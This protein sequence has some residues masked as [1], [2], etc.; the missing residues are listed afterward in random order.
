MCA[1]F[2]LFLV[3][4]EQQKL[5][6]GGEAAIWGEYVDATNIVSRLFPVVGATAEKLWSPM[7]ASTTDDA[8]WRLDEQRCRLIG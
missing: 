3:T 6:L 7:D 8:I 5:V 4:E 1:Y 2:F